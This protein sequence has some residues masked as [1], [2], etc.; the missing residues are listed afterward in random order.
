[1]AIGPGGEVDSPVLRAA[2]CFVVIVAIVLAGLGTTRLFVSA[3]AHED[4]PDIAHGTI[5]SWTT[6]CGTVANHAGH[7]VL[8][9]TAQGTALNASDYAICHQLRDALL[10]QALALWVTSVVV[11]VVGLAMTWPRRGRQQHR[12]PPTGEPQLDASPT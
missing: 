2:R 7:P 11:L 10:R 3:V 9:G 8:A 4:T 12:K 5:V 6:S 1:M